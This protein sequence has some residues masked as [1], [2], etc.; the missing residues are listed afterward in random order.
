MVEEK[1]IYPKTGEEKMP[2]WL[3]GI[4]K[5]APL[6]KYMKMAFNSKCDCEVCKTL[7]EDAKNLTK[8][9]GTPGVPK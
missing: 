4:D 6:A 3:E 9:F 7:R 8:L 2:E 5:M 1:D